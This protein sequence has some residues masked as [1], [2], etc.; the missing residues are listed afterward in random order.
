MCSFIVMYFTAARS[1]DLLLTAIFSAFHF[2]GFQI[3]L[4]I[5]SA[6]MTEDKH[7]HHIDGY[8]PYY[9]TLSHG[10]VLA[11]FGSFLLCF[12]VEYSLFIVALF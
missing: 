11:L 10:F 9:S 1:V 3:F 5:K 8:F 6:Q 12:D 7:P 2:F 4:L